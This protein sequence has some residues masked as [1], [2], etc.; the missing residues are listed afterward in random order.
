VWL[1]HG[2]GRVIFPEPQQLEEV[3]IQRLAPLR[4]VDDSNNVTEAYPMNPNG[5]PRGIAA[6]C[7]QDG[8]HLA[9]MPHP[10]RCF[11]SWQNPIVPHWPQKGQAAP[12]LKMFQNARDW[13]DEIDGR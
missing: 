2:E 4:Y 9:L 11:Q 7:S 6:L 12:W 3:E 10:E 13:C 8:R 5:S 1:A